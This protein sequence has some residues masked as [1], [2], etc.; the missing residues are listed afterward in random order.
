LNFTE[1]N[2]SLPTISPAPYGYADANTFD[3][4]YNN[5]PVVPLWEFFTSF[6]TALQFTTIPSSYPASYF[7]GYL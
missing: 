6:P 1:Q 7:E 5:Q 4:M 2:F 3:A